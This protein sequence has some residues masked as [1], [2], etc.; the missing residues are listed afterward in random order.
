MA[1]GRELTDAVLASLSDEQ[2][3]ILQELGELAVKKLKVSRALEQFTE[4]IAAS[5]RSLGFQ[6]KDKPTGLHEDPEV[7]ALVTVRER[8]KLTNIAE[9]IR[10][11]LR[12]AVDV[13]L[14]DLALVQRQ[15]ELYEVDPTP[16]ASDRKYF[17]DPTAAA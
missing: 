1:K 15:C 10:R 4:Q 9:Q 2:L 5:Q 13:G 12:R 3:T 16:G 17:E 7:V 6:A 8:F 14:G 11:T